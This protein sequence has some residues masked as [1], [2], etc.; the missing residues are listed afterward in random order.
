VACESGGQTISSSSG[1]IFDIGHI[2][3]LPPHHLRLDQTLPEPTGLLC[4]GASTSQ[5]MEE[6]EHYT[7]DEDD[8]NESTGDVECEKPK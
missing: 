4:Y 3:Q 6:E 2:R 7:H 5:E 1:G 8:V